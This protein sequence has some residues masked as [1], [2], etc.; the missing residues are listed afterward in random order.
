MR[1]VLFGSGGPLSL[2]ALETLSAAVSLVAVV[3]PGEGKVRGARSAARALGRWRSR[4]GLVAAAARR[5]IAVLRHRPGADQELV[6]GLRRLQPDLAC[7]ATFPCLLSAATLAVPPRGT[8]GVH[9]SLLPRHRGP[10]PLFWTYFHDDAEAGVTVHWLDASEDTGDVVFQE[11]VPLSRG[12]PGA[13]LYAEIARRGAALLA[14]AVSEIEAGTAPR[15]PQDVS[16]ATRE[17]APERG[18]WGIDF[19]TWGAERVWHFLRGIS[20]MGLEA[21]GPRPDAGGRVLLHGPVRGYRLEPQAGMRGEMVRVAGG[22]RLVCRD[23]VVELDAAS[24]AR[25]AWWTVRRLAAFARGRPAVPS[26]RRRAAGE[27]TGTRSSG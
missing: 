13:E 12:R 19:E 26:P 21:V 10:A 8:L 11:G 9:P 4:R 24:R 15:I 22:F 1:V 7:V 17:P 2:A 5:R 25:R 3:V 16:R 20:G 23:G 18:G 27:R 6:G 14:R